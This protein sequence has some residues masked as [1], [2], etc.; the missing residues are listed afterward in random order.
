MVEIKREVFRAYDIRG[1]VGRDFDPE[2]VERLGRALGTYFLSRGFARVVVGRDCRQSSPEYQSRLVAGLAATG[3]DVAVIGLTSTPV[4]YFA[5]RRL[6]FPAGVMVTAS[7][8]PPEFNGFKIWGG[9][10]VLT[11]EEIGDV[12]R[13]MVAGQFADGRGLVSEHDILP[14]YLEEVAA[15]VRLERP[16]RIVVDGGNG[17]G[18]EITARLLER[19]GAEVVRLDR[20]SVV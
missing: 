14:T 16:V 7:H 2:W 15:G 10:C 9:E 20:K 12:H 4:F 3:C 11:P 19:A 18:G 1:V 5:V 6:A 13:I 8:N 17:A